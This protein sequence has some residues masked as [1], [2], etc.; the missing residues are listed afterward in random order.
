MVHTSI[1]APRL[2]AGL[3]LAERPSPA[4]IAAYSGVIAIHAAALSL[5]LMPMAAPV[6][7][8]AH[9]SIP[10]TWVLPRRIEVIPVAPPR[11]D[12]PRAEVRRL[13]RPQPHVQPPAAD[14]PV[15]ADRGEQASTD[16]GPVDL[17][18]P[19]LS[20]QP[21]IA[22]VRLE[23]ADAPAPAYP[24][25]ALR[26]RIEG[27][28]MLQVLVDVDGR[29]LDVLVQ[30]SS[31]SRVLDEAA[32]VQVLRRWRFRPAMQDG[33]AIQAMGLVPVVFRLR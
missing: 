13:V 24:R 15:L 2:Q 33:M 4:R 6:L 5:L 10:I 11:Q 14:V 25:E 9:E 21:A 1:H 30:H 31:G 32:R 19:G 22:A 16:P 26:R 12:P 23:Y 8:Q 27:T 29:P 3:H 28:V 7:P 18:G 20:A 17:P